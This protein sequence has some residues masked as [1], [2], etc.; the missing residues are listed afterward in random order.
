MLHSRVLL[1]PA[2]AVA[3]MAVQAPKAE[4]SSQHLRCLSPFI[5]TQTH[6]SSIR[7][8]FAREFPSLE[9]AEVGK[10]KISGRRNCNAH[11][12]GLQ[13]GISRT[14]T[15]RYRLFITMLCSNID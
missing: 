2:A 1:V 9:A 5:K 15:G 12:G 4:A 3:L 10:S 14:S 8:S 13:S 6:S 11:V 7:C